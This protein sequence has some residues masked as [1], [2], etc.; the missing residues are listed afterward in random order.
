VIITIIK[1]SNLCKLLAVVRV[2]ISV[3][4]VVIFLITPVILHID[5][6]TFMYLCAGLCE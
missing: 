5:R 1:G 2:V 3:V 6:V 4:R